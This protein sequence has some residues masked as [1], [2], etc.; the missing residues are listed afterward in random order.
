[1]LQEKTMAGCK[2]C[3]GCSP[4]PKFKSVAK[5]EKLEQGERSSNPR[6][7]L[8][9]VGSQA[10]YADDQVQMIVNVVSDESDDTCDCFTLKPQRILKNRGEPKSLTE[11]FRVSQ[12]AGAKC[13]KLQAL[14]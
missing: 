10:I 13:W 7:P 6:Y 5:A 2:S 4:E 3:S 14:L 9:L 1:M 12:E 11:D 8:V